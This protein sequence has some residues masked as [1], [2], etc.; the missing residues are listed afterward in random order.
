MSSQPASSF[1]T[2]NPQWREIVTVQGRM[3]TF[4]YFNT[5]FT[6]GLIERQEVIGEKTVI[7]FEN[8]DD[9]LTYL[10]VRFEAVSGEEPCKDDYVFD[11]RHCG[12]VRIRKMVQKFEKAVARDAESQIA[13]IVFDF[14]YNRIEIKHHMAPLQLSPKVEDFS[15]ELFTK[16][17]SNSDNSGSLSPEMQ[18]KLEQ[19]YQ[20]ERDCLSK[21][22]QS[23]VEIANDV[24]LLHGKK[25]PSFVESNS[26]ELGSR[27]L[28][29]SNQNGLGSNGHKAI[30]KGSQSQDSLDLN[31]LSDPVLPLLEAKG[32]LGKQ[33]TA[34]QVEEVKQ[35]ALERLQERFVQRAEVM[36]VRF[37]EERERVA[38]LKHELMSSIEAGKTDE[39]VDKTFSEVLHKNS[40][41]L[42]IL[43]ERLFNFQKTAFEKFTQLQL[44]LSEDPRLKVV[45][46]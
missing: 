44:S 46:A 14:H 3:M 40:L 23:E 6:D 28:P 12:R 30:V 26:R 37:E 8:R 13:K 32:L 42:A 34:A 29:G 4:S 9:K 45:S 41:K 39:A 15:R 33:L 20:M 7:R 21:I 25:R 38:Q 2:A 5:R 31:A 43:E 11:N 27:D 24:G 22:K 35:E 19:L 1:L 18:A 36:R 16:V 10:S 17:N